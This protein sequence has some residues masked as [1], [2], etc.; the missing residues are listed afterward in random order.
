MLILIY[1]EGVVK[2]NKKSWCEDWKMLKEK[3]QLMIWA[4]FGKEGLRDKFIN[5]FDNLAYP[6][7]L[8]KNALFNY[9]LY[10]FNKI[11]NRCNGSG[12]YSYNQRSGRT[13]FK[14][15]GTKY[16]V[17]VPGKSQLEKL[18]IKYPEGVQYSEDLKNGKIKGKGVFL[19]KFKSKEVG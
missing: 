7:D 10:G 13:C 18:M 6:E 8:K 19:A 9:R 11:C 2:V 14:C 12:E 4:M 17:A 15:A 1:R 16:E 3:D 5:D